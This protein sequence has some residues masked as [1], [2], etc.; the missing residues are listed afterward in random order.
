MG[1]PGPIYT[2]TQEG[3]KA[4]GF[5]YGIIPEKG[6]PVTGS[7]DNFRAWWREIV[8]FDQGAAAALANC[9]AAAEKPDAV[10]L[11]SYMHR[12]QE[13]QDTTLAGVASFSS[14]EVL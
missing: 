2:P 10:E 5:I 3:C 14:H 13:L 9:V 1:R 4:R 12:L 8:K 11:A 6:K 7:S